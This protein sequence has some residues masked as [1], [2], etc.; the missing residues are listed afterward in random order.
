MSDSP[1]YLAIMAARRATA[2]KRER[3]A[4]LRRWTLWL[5]LVAT[6]LGAGAWGRA[7]MRAHPQHLPWT[8]LAVGQPVGWATARKVAELS[9]DG[10]ACRRVLRA[11]AVDFAPLPRVGA[12]ECVAADR[13]RLADDVVPGLT[14][15]PAGVAPACG[16]SVALILWMR[17]R[18]QPAAE[19][20][21]GQGVARVEHLGSYS[22]RRIGGGA[23]GTWSEHATGNAIDVSAFVLEDGTRIALKADWRNPVDGPRSRFLADVR[24]GACELFS[25]VL[26]PDYNSAHA[27][28]FHLDQAARPAGWGVCR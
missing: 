7:W 1:A 24:D 27:D 3:A 19:R 20:H 26:S 8:P 16:V 4:T 23:S 21:F 28:H 22:C 18:V 13:T 10:A 14:L 17:E 25:T 12:G 9:A 6:I 15:R 11:G 2:A 5:L